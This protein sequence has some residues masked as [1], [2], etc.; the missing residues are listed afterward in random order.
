M[1]LVARRPETS[2]INEQVSVLLTQRRAMKAFFG[3]LRMISGKAFL[4]RESNMKEGKQSD[5]VTAGRKE[6]K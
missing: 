3:C 5:G 1:P 4:L 6:D 2:L